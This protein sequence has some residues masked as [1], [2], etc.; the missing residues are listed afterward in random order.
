M[1]ALLS[2]APAALPRAA[3]AGAVG[4]DAGEAMLR[5]APAGLLPTRLPVEGGER[6]RVGGFARAF[7]A[8]DAVAVRD[9]ESDWDRYSP[10]AGRNAAIEMLQAELTASRGAWEAALVARHELVIDGSRGAWD[11]VRADRRREGLAAGTRLDIDAAA[12][13]VGWGGVRV[14]RTW[15]LPAAEAAGTWRL[16][17]GATLLSVRRLQGFEAGGRIG[18]DGKSYSF[19]AAGWRRDSWRE[20]A[21]FGT[22]RTTGSGASADFGLAWQAASG[23]AFANLSLVDALSTL[24]IDGVATHSFVAAMLDHLDRR[25]RQVT[26]RTKPSAPLAGATPRGRCARGSRARRV[27]SRA[28]PS[29]RPGE[30]RSPACASSTSRG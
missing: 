3:P 9:F 16:T 4:A 25:R 13:G 20:F 19:D 23:R 24:R 1:A 29:M 27:C 8:T 7:D 30:R 5:L 15:R 12:M 10:R 21:G 6:W 22:P 26:S 17:A 18:F 11:A 14:A 28:P 2:A